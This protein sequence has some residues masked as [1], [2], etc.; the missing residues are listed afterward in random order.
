M[1]VPVL[2]DLDTEPPVYPWGM[3]PAHLRTRYQLRAA[4]LRP[5]RQPPAA[6]LLWAS[7]RGGRPRIGPYRFARLY[8][9]RLARPRLRPTQAQLAALARALEARRT[10]PECSQQKPYV[11]S[12]RLGVCND[13]ATR[14]Q[15][16]A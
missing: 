13:C 14:L 8:D 9:V 10:C 3:A 1:T 6:L 4:G 15:V 7:R 11:L 2:T 5:G 12:A 16:A